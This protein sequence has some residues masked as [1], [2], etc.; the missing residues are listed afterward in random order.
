MLDNTKTYFGVCCFG[1]STELRRGLCCTPNCNTTVTTGNKTADAYSSIVVSGD[2]I[3][4][5][6]G[7]NAPDVKV[8]MTKK[9]S[10]AIS[11][12]PN[13]GVTTA[14]GINKTHIVAAGC[15]SG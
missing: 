8:Y 6:Y 15:Q 10:I 9:G 7:V 12:I 2:T 11:A 13:Y 3:T 1:N 4:N 14:T 5:V